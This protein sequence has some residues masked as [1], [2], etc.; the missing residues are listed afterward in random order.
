RG[1]EANRRVS[2]WPETGREPDRRADQSPFFKETMSELL[3]SDITEET[4]AVA[5][6]NYLAKVDEVAKLEPCGIHYIEADPPAAGSDVAHVVAR[7]A[8]AHRKDYYRRYESGSW[9]P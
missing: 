4:A 5:L 1:G 7:T 2:P 3:Q 6:L 9:T 8:G